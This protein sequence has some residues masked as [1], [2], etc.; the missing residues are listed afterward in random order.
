MNGGEKGP[1][2]ICSF[3]TI[4]ASPG[5]RLTLNFAAGS[6]GLALIVMAR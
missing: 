3:D 4:V 1:V 2:T 5:D 6:A